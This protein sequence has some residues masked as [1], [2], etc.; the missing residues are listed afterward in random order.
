LRYW[1][2]RF[3]TFLFFM[4]TLSRTDSCE[5]NKICG[6][7]HNE[8]RK[9]EYAFF[10]IFLRFYTDFTRINTTQVLFKIHFCTSAPDRFSGFTDKS[11]VHEK[12]PGI[13]S[14]LAI[15]SLGPMG[16]AAR[17]GLRPG[18]LGKRRRSLQM[19]DLGPRKG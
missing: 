19:L 12:L 6:I 18:K 11:L 1:R 9:I 8:S 17:W 10:L 5:N 7:F 16:A 2:S 13:N 4:Q 15:G 14:Y 3:F